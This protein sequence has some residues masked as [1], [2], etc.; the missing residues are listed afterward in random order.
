MK[1]EN[2]TDIEVWEQARNFIYEVYNIFTGGNS[3]NDFGFRDKI[4]RAS[5]SIMFNIAK[6]F[7]SGSKM[8]FI[9]FLTYS[10]LSASEV[11]SLL[12]CCL[13]YTLYRCKSA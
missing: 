9:Y 6:G 2:F 11:Q 7:D 13:G 4:P 8:S 3:K 1:I 12:K 5:V 10:F